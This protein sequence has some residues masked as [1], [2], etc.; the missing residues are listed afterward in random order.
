MKKRIASIEEQIERLMLKKQTLEQTEEKKEFSREENV[1]A[2]LIFRKRLTM[3]EFTG[4][5]PTRKL[6]SVRVRVQ[7][8][9]YMAGAGTMSGI[10]KDARDAYLKYHDANPD[11][12]LWMYQNFPAYL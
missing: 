12:L 10:S 9:H 4:R 2:L 11:G 1:G 6:G 7:N 5:F 8:Y 3:A